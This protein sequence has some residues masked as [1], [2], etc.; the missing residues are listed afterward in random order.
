M[1]HFIRSIRPDQ[2]DYLVESP[3]AFVIEYLTEHLP[4]I[5]F[6]RVNALAGDCFFGEYLLV[7]ELLHADI[8]AGKPASFRTGEVKIRFNSDG[9]V[10]YAKWSAIPFAAGDGSLP[11]RPLWL[12][13]EF[14]D[15][16]PME[17][18]L[19][20]P[21]YALDPFDG[22][23]DFQPVRKNSSEVL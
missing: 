13:S 14:W 12:P 4:C 22:A 8:W 23:A 21:D 18:K 17:V 16:I 2:F 3:E 1:T 7:F 19:D 10:K 5:E 9:S 15:I 6:T 20:D 11:V